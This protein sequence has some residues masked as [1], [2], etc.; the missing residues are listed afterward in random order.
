MKVVE[1]NGYKLITVGGENS[2][3]DDQESKDK[4]PTSLPT[5]G[6]M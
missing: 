1:A 2:S 5:G 3:S 4:A 6:T